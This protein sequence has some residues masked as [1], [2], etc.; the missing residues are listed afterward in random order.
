[1]V[2]YVTKINSCAVAKAPDAISVL[3]KR[4]GGGYYQK[5]Y[6]AFFHTA[7]LLKKRGFLSPLF[8]FI[9][10][11]TVNLLVCLN[12]LFISKCPV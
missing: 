3:C 8:V 6:N 11:I 5:Q 12:V 4:M 10:L 7:N 2:I 1:M 9:Y